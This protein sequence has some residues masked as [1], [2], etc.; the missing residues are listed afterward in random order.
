M[1]RGGLAIIH[2]N[3][4]VVRDFRLPTG[5]IQPKALEMQLVRITS[6]NSCSVVLANIYRPPRCPVPEFLD[7]LADVVRSI[8]TASNDR[9]ILCGDVNCPSVDGTCTDD[10]LVDSSELDKFITSPTRDDNLLDILAT[11]TAE[12]LSNVE[13][14]DAGGI[15][16]H[17]L[18]HANLAFSVPTTRIMTSTFRNMKKI[19][20][21]SFETVLRN[22]IFTSTAITV[23]AFIDQ[24]IN[25]ITDEIDKVAPCKRC[26]RRPSKPIT[27]LLS[28]QAIAAKR[29][30]RKFERKW[31]STRGESDRVNYRRA[32]RRA[33]R[34]INES[35]LVYFHRRLSDCTDWGQQWKVAKELL[36]SSDRDLARTD[37]KNH[38]LCMTFVTFFS[39]SG[40]APSKTPLVEKSH[41]SFILPIFPIFHSLALHLTYFLLSH[42]PRFLT[43]Q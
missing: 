19:V 34:L 24:M 28:D 11:D 13:I 18:V 33:N 23:D 12:S 39:S 35:Q 17:R 3:S 6:L 5:S 7:E 14:G 10:S 25:I 2:R 29:E 16:D 9:L 21:A 38:T 37:A 22:S 27:K 4:L 36:H 41:P 43:H 20:T 26:A 31:K 32:C 8:Y 1:R 15:S 30:R 40:S 42:Q